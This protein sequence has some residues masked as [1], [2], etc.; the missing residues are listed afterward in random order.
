MT[1]LD[2]FTLFFS[3]M[4]VLPALLIFRIVF[5]ELRRR[6]ADLALQTALAGGAAADRKPGSP[7]N[8]RARRDL[9]HSFDVGTENSVRMS[10]LPSGAMTGDGEHS[11]FDFEYT[12]RRQPGALRTESLDMGGFSQIPLSLTDRA[13]NCFIIQRRLSLN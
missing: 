4:A 12:I 2:L 1:E 6:R 3:S 13:G 5:L 8:E 11:E 10:S 9:W 7:A